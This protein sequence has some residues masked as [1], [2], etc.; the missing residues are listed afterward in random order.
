[1]ETK[2][3][4]EQAEPLSREQHILLKSRELMFRYG[5]K[6]LT[7]D[8]IA[9][10]LGIS[11]KTL[12]QVVANKAE[13]VDKMM[14]I[15]INERR[16][17]CIEAEAENAIDEMLNIYRNHS[18]M[19]KRINLK[20]VYELRKYFPESWQKMEAFRNDF[21]FKSVC[22]NLQKGIKAGLY[23]S[24]LN[25]VIIAKFY[26]ARVFDLVNPEL[27]PIGEFSSDSLFHEMFLYHIHGIASDKGLKYLKEHIKLDF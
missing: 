13:L 22:E 11:K 5:V 18:Q 2:I 16:I 8:D 3:Y 7:M 9:H 1:L 19:I 15:T 21:I 23:R 24:E 25:T 4:R 26:S 27:F 20:L 12:Y 17:E 6:S 14:D 10:H